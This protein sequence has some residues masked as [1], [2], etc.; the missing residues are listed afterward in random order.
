[1]SYKYRDYVCPYCFNQVDKCKC[2]QKPESLVMIDKNLQSAIRTLNQK[3]Y[4]TF[5]CC[6]GHFYRHDVEHY[7]LFHQTVELDSIPS[8]FKKANHYKKIS[9]RYHDR[10]NEENF[11]LE[12]QKAIENLNE[13][14]D[15]LSVKE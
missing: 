6:E 1:M 8:G 12:K 13:W 2:K 9:Y 3:G 11:E 5:G 14:I 7:I 15:S 10:N 4:K